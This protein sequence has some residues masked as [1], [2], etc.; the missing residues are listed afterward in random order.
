MA[1][2][3]NSRRLLAVLAGVSATVAL[4]SAG[5]FSA[6]PDAPSVTRLHARVPAPLVH[7]PQVA[8]AAP[9]FA[10]PPASVSAVLPLPDEEKPQA[11]VSPKDSNPE[12]PPVETYYA[13]MKKLEAS[14]YQPPTSDRKM[15]YAAIRGMLASLGDP[16]TVFFDPAEY[17]RMQQENEGEFGGIGAR[18]EKVSGKTVI[19]EIVPDTPA[20]RGGLKAGDAILA[21]DGKPIAGVNLIEVV[22]KIRGAVGT[23]VKLTLERKGKPTFVK[24]IIRQIVKLETLKAEMVL[25]AA[26]K[27]T[28][29]AHVSLYAFNLQAHAELDTAL[30]RMAAKGMKALVLDLRGNP[31]GFLQEAIEVASRFLD[32]GPVVI[33]QQRGGE[34]STYGVVRGAK[35]Y[36]VPLVVLVNKG[37]ASASE[38]VAG[39]VK[40]T[41]SG[42][43]V[44]TDTYGKGLVQTINPIQNDGSAFKLTTQRY[45]TPNGTDI[46]K[47]GIAPH[48]KVELTK[49]DIEKK[50]DPQLDKAVAILK[51]D[52]NPAAVSAARAASK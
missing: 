35:R 48:F 15:T 28:T 21:V 14:Y 12:M 52:L 6:R 7:G 4:F 24:T 20:L 10:P 11:T 23:P 47:K 1:F 32:S 18:L 9:V 29:I 31:G 5:W 27:P 3:R 8:A 45:F 17:R 38:I 26:K 46:N 2:H 30:K 34:R 33:L 42:I 50:R 22:D 37:S 43:L 39:A 16:Y 19:K 49:E 41:S 51:G 36:H 13:V 44:G 40:D 25:D